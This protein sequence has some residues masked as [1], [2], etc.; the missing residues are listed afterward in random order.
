MTGPSEDADTMLAGFRQQIEQK[1]KQAEQLKQAAS[2]VQVSASSADGAVTVVVDNNG[3]MADLDLTDD[4]LRKRPDEVSRQILA[5][6]RSAQT[7]LA[8]RMQE[9]MAPVVGED[10]ETLDA[11]MSGFRERFPAEEAED[12]KAAQQ[13]SAQ[14]EPDDFGNGSWLDDRRGW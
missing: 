8:A 6:L 1:F 2:A 5:T 12:P 11:V 14:E 7:Q 13:A 4:A 3:N 9:V 10:S